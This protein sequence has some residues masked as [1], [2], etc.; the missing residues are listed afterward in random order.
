MSTSKFSPRAAA[1]GE[2]PPRPEYSNWGRWG[3]DDEQGAANHSTPAS[4]LAAL[5]LAQSGEIVPLGQVVGDRDAPRN[6]PPP[7]HFMMRDAGD[8]LAGM[9]APS[10]FQSAT[11]HL[12]LAVH[13]G[14]THLDAL[15]HVWYG[16]TL[17]NGYPH[18]NV[19][20]GGLRKLGID[21][22]PPLVS[23]GVLVD[24]PR[25]RG[26]ERLP[27]GCEITAA[28]IAEVL[29]ADRIALEAGDAVLIRTGWITAYT[30][31]DA[32]YHGDR[33][34]IGLDAA[35]YLARADV[36]LVG[37]DNSG[38]EVIPWAPGTV[39]PVHQFLIRD[40]GIY[41]LEFLDLEELSRR[42][43]TSF[44]FIALPLRLRGATGSP[45]SPIAVL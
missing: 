2:T 25:H 15:G 40:C 24:L 21:K 7:Q 23:R 33:P 34:G 38:V 3:A 6:G 17:Y 1:D 36:T 20:S 42:R 41:L 22:A 32:E 30:D 29:E 5:S 26:V 35:E 18:T 43:A 27:A 45:I 19:R 37:A 13:G 28:D 11:D 4:V 12:S 16:D 39:C 31:P 8:F 44:L 9:K 14:T 10:G